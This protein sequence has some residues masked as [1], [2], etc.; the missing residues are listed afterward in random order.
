M[1]SPRLRELH[2]VWGC[3]RQTFSETNFGPR[4]D[5][6]P[7]ISGADPSSAERTQFG[8]SSYPQ[9]ISHGEGNRVLYGTLGLRAA[10]RSRCN[11]LTQNVFGATAVCGR[12]PFRAML[13]RGVGQELGVAC[14]W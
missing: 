1:V 5:K 14:Q 6:V 12:Q 9:R 10:P 11:H 7:P 13:A 4:L 3:F 8:S 2:F